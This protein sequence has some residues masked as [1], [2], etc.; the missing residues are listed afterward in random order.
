[1]CTRQRFSENR[2]YKDGQSV[3]GITGSCPSSETTNTI[4]SSTRKHNSTVETMIRER[5]ERERER[6]RDIEKDGK[7][8]IIRNKINI[9][10]TTTTTR[11]LSSAFY[12]LSRYRIGV[13]PQQSI[14]HYQQQQ[15][16]Q[17]QCRHSSW[18]L[19]QNRRYLS[20]TTTS[21]NSTATNNSS[22]SS[23]SK[24]SSSSKSSSFAKE[25]YVHPLSQIVLTHL[26]ESQ[27]DFLQ[28]YGLMVDNS[29]TFHKDGTFTLAFPS[30]TPTTNIPTTNT[31]QHQP[32][33]PLLQPHNNKNRIWTWYEPFEK[34]HWLSIERED[35]G[36]G[37]YLMQD[38]KKSAWQD[39]DTTH[40]NI[41]NATD[42]MVQKVLS[43][44]NNEKK[45]NDQHE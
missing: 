29:L 27:S 28:Q 24:S 5:R 15:Q 16:Q 8:N 22:L 40:E 23:P 2:R 42:T 10:S 14:H 37:S 44:T 1:M 3:L 33:H 45:N 9:M 35:F 19:R 31:Q 11:L 6:E 20:S 25:Q 12:R 43:I 39:S 38:N 36:V 17:Q 41:I 32:H 18:L 21:A 26:Q 4:H 7:E 13:G 30:N 34:K